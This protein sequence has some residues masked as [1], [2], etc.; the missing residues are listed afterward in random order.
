MSARMIKPGCVV[1]AT[2]LAVALSACNSTPKKKPPPPKPRS[3]DLEMP[4]PPREQRL[5]EERTQGDPTAHT[6]EP[7][8]A[9]PEPSS[10]AAE[11]MVED[12]MVEETD[13]PTSG[14]RP[15]AEQ[16]EAS[17][18]ASGGGGGAPMAGARN[19][20]AQAQGATGSPAPAGGPTGPG[21]VA[22]EIRI[23]NQSGPP[24]A[25]SGGTR[26]GLPDGR[27]LLEEQPEARGIGGGAP[28]GSGLGST[29]DWTGEADPHTPPPGPDRRAMPPDVPDDDIVARQLREAAL[30]EQDPVLREKL[31]QEYHRYK[32]GL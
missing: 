28:S 6:G 3:S 5:S 20:P 30:A 22:P 19:A 21:L 24:P 10:D 18:G 13:E 32:A 4:S 29:P 26:K 15:S 8:D 31:W 16:G 9:F 14:G 2:V 7:A 23:G 11:I 17:D 25:P 27:G 12:I 1:L